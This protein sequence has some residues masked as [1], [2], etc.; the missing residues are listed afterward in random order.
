MIPIQVLL[1]E[2]QLVEEFQAAMT[3]RNVSEKFF[4]WF[5]LSVK[6]WLQLCTDGAYRNFMRS[7]TLLQRHVADIVSH[8][9]EREVEVLSLGS[10]QGNKDVLILEALRASGL[11]ARYRPV[12]ASQAL[13]E[14]AC[15]TAIEAR[16]PCHGVKADIMSTDH[17]T[18]LKVDNPSCPRLALLLGNTLG[19]FDPPG[20]CERLGQMLNPGDYLFV[21]G[22]I[23]ADTD[24]MA[25]YDNP[26]NRQF[27]FA[28]LRSVGITDHDGELCFEAVHDE[29]RPGLHLI[30]KH[31]RAG[32]ELDL[33]IAGKTLRLNPDER[34]EMNFSYK[35]APE[36]FLSLLSEVEGLQCLA[37]YHSEDGRYLSALVRRNT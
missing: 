34:I 11:R 10:G 13:L 26:L 18:A 36:T 20:Y 8:L 6:A 9:P 5:P 31:F 14:I 22:E 19:A 37:E 25:G 27:A 23:F 21:D 29:R 15:A 17:L 24:T 30:S 1:T 4:Y 3:A 7:Y 12:D 35:F 32:R 33:T 16:F 28:P 2:Y